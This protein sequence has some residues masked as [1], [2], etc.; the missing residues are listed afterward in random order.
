MDSF[1]SMLISKCNYI[2]QITNCTVIWHY[3]FCYGIFI[4]LSPFL[5]RTKTETMTNCSFYVSAL[6][7]LRVQPYCWFWLQCVLHWCHYSLV[8]WFIVVINFSECISEACAISL[9]TAISTKKKNFWMHW[10]RD[11]K[12]SK[13]SKCVKYWSKKTY[14]QNA[15]YNEIHQFS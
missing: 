13:L 10:I 7:V 2:K 6:V 15:H 9:M 1:H 12:A 3:N 8:L 14:T 4:D 11:S 5:N